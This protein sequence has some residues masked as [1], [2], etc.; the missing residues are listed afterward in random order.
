MAVVDGVPSEPRTPFCDNSRDDL[1][2]V[3]AE[4]WGVV[5]VIDGVLDQVAS[6]ILT[7]PRESYADLCYVPARDRLYCLYYE[8]AM[9]LVDCANVRLGGTRMLT[10]HTGFI[11]LG[12]TKAYCLDGIGE[13][14][15]AL[16]G[17]RDSVVG[18][19]PCDRVGGP[20]AIVSESGKLYCRQADSSLAVFDLAGDS[21]FRVVNVPHR[22]GALVPDPTRGRLFIGG[23]WG[24]S[25]F[26][27]LDARADTLLASIV[28]GLD[29]C[30]YAYSPAQNRLYAFTL[31]DRALVVDC[32]LYQVVRTLLVP[33]RIGRSLWNPRN[34]RVYA[35]VGGSILVVLDCAR[36]SVVAYCYLGDGVGRLELDTA[37]NRLFV[38]TAH[39]LRVYDCWGDT[40]VA[41]LGVVGGGHMAWCPEHHRLFIST[42][43]TTV[44]VVREA[45][46]VEEV[47]DP[48]S[49]SPR[50]DATVVH[51][52]LWLGAGTAPRSGASGALGLSR[53][54][55]LDATGRRVAVL[56]PGR[57]DISR[58]P[59]GVY[60]IVEPGQ[61][62]RR[63]VVKME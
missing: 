62:S 52:V 17:S 16:G 11:G 36:D 31:T 19:I 18:V 8:G 24:Q 37:G 13:R 14:I 58:L 12:D 45:V 55:L 10:C 9:Y 30:S 32:S 63:K 44:T 56:E 22:F 50:L 7:G 51:G 27:V 48:Q 15:V 34:D 35:V 25:R 59:A 53:A 41:S 40:L 60:V 57:N 28:L 46:G 4:E 20:A 21:L 2:Y 61:A 26:S 39:Q 5:S 54:G 47:P 6:I 42:S 38:T 49:P 1:V 3:G 23:T 33:P 43:E 29:P